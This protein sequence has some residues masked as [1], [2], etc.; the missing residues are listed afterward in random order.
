MASSIDREDGH[1]GFQIAPMV[2][3]VFVLMLFFMATAGSMVV[4]KELALQIPS[5]RGA[6]TAIVIQISAD[7]QVSMNDKDFGLP[8][9]HA[10]P[11][12][13]LWFKDTIA[14][15]GES[16]PV[17]IRPNADARHERIIDVLNAINAAGVKKV[18]FG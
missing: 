18:T 14:M 2:D 8:V 15:F 17:V 5:G 16:D 9:D 3:V 6:E 4:E 11:S 10:L 7:G 12:L 1:F 13:R